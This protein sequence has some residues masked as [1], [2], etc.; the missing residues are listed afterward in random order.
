MINKYTITLNINH[1]VKTYDLDIHACGYN[2]TIHEVLFASQ[3]IL[4]GLKTYFLIENDII[5]DPMFSRRS[6]DDAIG[7]SRDVAFEE[8]L[9]L[10]PLEDE[11]GSLSNI[12]WDND[13]TNN[14]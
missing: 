12:Y 4:N 1:G 7:Y 3:V 2:A 13:I 8:H 11:Y 14:I 9:D 10:P 5:N 6:N